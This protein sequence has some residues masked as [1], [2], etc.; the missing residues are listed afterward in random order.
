MLL[1]T[2]DVF[3]RFNHLVVGVSTMNERIVCQLMVINKSDIELLHS[4]IQKI[5]LTIPDVFVAISIVDHV[6]TDGVLAYLSAKN[7]RNVGSYSQDFGAGGKLNTYLKYNNIDPELLE[8]NID[9]D[10]DFKVESGFVAGE[11][12]FG[13]DLEA[14]PETFYGTHREQDS[15]VT[16]GFVASETF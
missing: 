10:D 6:L 16:T 12:F 13:A 4:T 7:F 11:T 2:N 8:P 9:L 15:V 5:K 1:L 3:K 14:G